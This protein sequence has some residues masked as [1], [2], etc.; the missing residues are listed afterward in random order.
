MTEDN[1]PAV[2]PHPSGAAPSTSEAAQALPEHPPQPEREPFWNYSELLMFLGLSIP[3]ML[4]GFGVV[5]GII[6]LAHLETP[7]RAVE[8]LAAQSLGYT[9]LFLVLRAMFRMQYG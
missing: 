8:L 6:L 3:C 7:L 2:P 5:K 4:A 1:A 9:L